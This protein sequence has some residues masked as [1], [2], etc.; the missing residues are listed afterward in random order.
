MIVTSVKAVPLRLP[1]SVHHAASPASPGS[2]ARW[3]GGSVRVAALAGSRSR[4][5]EV[6]RPMPFAVS[7][8]FSS[9]G[10]ALSIGLGRAG[11]QWPP[12][13]STDGSLTFAPAIFF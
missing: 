10:F 6:S 9:H 13:V 7:F 4:I 5:L 2:N 12:T 1:I 8:D 11:R 3:R